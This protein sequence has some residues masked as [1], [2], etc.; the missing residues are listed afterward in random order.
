MQFAQDCIQRADDFDD[1]IWNDETS[2][3]L[4]CHRRRCFRKTNQPPRL[5]PKPKHPVTVHIWG[6]ISKRGATEVYIFEG[7]WMQH[8][9]FES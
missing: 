4:K 2:I 3:Q 1:V 9:T 7:K 5:K 8:F 6:A